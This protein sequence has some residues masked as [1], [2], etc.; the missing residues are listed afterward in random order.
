MNAHRTRRRGAVRALYA[1]MLQALAQSASVMLRYGPCPRLA[2]RRLTTVA[3]PGGHHFSGDY[4][5][6]VRRIIE[7]L[8]PAPETTP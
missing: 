5:Q 7:H 1:T 3:M 8:Q 2:G 6:P 4:Q